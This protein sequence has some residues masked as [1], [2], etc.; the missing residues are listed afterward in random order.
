MSGKRVLFLNVAGLAP[1]HLDAAPNLA[2]LKKRGVAMPMRASFP[3]VTCT[4]QATLTTGRLPREHGIVANGWCERQSWSVAFWEQP[5]SLVQSPRVW[6]LIKAARSGATS[7]VLYWQQSMFA[8]SDVILTP[9][10][11]HLENQF[12]P[13]VYSQPVGYYEELADK[14]GDFKLQQY[15]GPVAGLGSSRWIASAAI[16]TLRRHKPTLTM[17]YLPHLD[18]DAQRYGPESAQSLQDLAEVDG[19]IG[20][21][22]AE[23]D[24]DT[25]ILVCSE[26]ALQPV[27]GAVLPNLEL[28]RAGLF[29]WREIGGWEFPDFEMSR[30]FAVVDHQVAH[31][32]CKPEATGETR[33]V[34]EKLEGVQAVLGRDQQKSLAIDHPRSG[35]LV[36]LAAPDRWFAYYWWE[37]LA[38]APPF[39]THIDIHRKPGYDPCELFVDWGATLAKFQWPPAVGRDPLRIRGSHGLPVEYGG[40]H[41]VC[42]LA[43]AGS[44]T[45]KLAAEVRDV[46][47]TPTILKLLGVEPNL[48]AAP[49]V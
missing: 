35:E 14:L 32:Y 37:D 16:Q 3:A 7:A 17:V 21:I 12:V 36:A 11:L 9:R 24:N 8:C 13:W 27:R 47:I 25:A 49:F 34:L 48:P 43:G 1:E 23:A 26:Y 38:K 22:V 45:V 20:E 30:A 15:W 28:R 19:L 31:I 40:R 18:Y 4:V 10:P 29:R 46:Q 6:D 2:A 5:A 44:E 33:E 42:L 41:A 39:S